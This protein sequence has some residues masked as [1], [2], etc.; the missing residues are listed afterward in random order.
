MRAG[1]DH[2]RRGATTFCGATAG[3]A[4]D[5]HGVVGAGRTDNTTI[6][7]VAVLVVGAL[8]LGSAHGDH[9]LAAARRADRRRPTTIVAGGKDV[10]HR[11]VAGLG[12]VGVTGAEIIGLRAVVVVAAD[13]RTPGVA[14]DVDATV[15]R[16]LD[17]ALVS[18]TAVGQVEAAR[19]VEDLGVRQPGERVDTL[20][21]Q[22]AVGI[23]PRE[24]CRVVIA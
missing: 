5:V 23:G 8:V 16:A 22:V 7:P 19:V 9:V 24:T 11:L 2:F 12:G 3:E 1:R 13:R 4:D 17:Q 21:A 15:L 10:D 6:G 20:S 18:A 14:G